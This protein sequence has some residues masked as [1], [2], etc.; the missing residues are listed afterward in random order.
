MEKHT[1]GPWRIHEFPDY[2]GGNP[3]YRIEADTT[4]FLTVSECSDGYISGQNEANAY[5]IAAA[6]DLLAACMKLV[7]AADCQSMNQVYDAT[8]LARAAIARATGGP[9]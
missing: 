7:E 5:L 4:L 3:W 8:E 6:P 9:P 1:P 2:E